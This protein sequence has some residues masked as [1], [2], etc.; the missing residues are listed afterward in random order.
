MNQKRKYY[1]IVLYFIFLIFLTYSCDWDDNRLKIEN[2]S[3]NPICYEI[4]TDSILK[5]PSVND[6][7]F[8]L[9]QKIM[10]GKTRTYYKAGKTRVWEDFIAKSESKMLYVFFFNYDTVKKNNWDTLRKYRKYLRM[11]YFSIDDLIRNNWRIKYK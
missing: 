11:E 3:P 9:D 6:K 10:P 5:I 7:G 2:N 4:Q 1:Y 8:Y